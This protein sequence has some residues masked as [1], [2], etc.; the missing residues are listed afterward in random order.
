MNITRGKVKTAIKMLVYG[1]E[2]VGK[3]TFAAQMPGAVFID[4]EGSTKHMDV[5]RFDAPVD[6]EDV[7][8]I[9][10]HVSKNPKDFGTIVEADVAQQVKTVSADSAEST[11]TYDL[12]GRRVTDTTKP[13]VY[14]RNGRK[15]VKR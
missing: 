6:L 14:V 3:T 1:P 11:A 9:L 13:G 12:Q 10:I 15:V 2:G 8:R 4:T 7:T 5:A